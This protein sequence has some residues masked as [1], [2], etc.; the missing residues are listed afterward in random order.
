MVIAGKDGRI[1]TRHGNC[2]GPCE[3]FFSKENQ[4]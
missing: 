1:T 4:P 3:F 2:L